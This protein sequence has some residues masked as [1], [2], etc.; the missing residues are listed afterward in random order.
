MIGWSVAALASHLG[1]SAVGDLSRVV[2]R[3][4]TLHQAT[5][6]DLAFAH[7][8]IPSRRIAESRAAVLLTTPQQWKEHSQQFVAAILSDD[9]YGDMERLMVEVYRHPLAECGKEIA[10]SAKV[11][12][13]AVIEGVVEEQVVIGPFCWVAKGS[14][15]GAGSQLDAGVHLYPGVDL[16]KD[17]HLLSHA[18]VGSQGFGFRYSSTG[19]RFPV[20][21]RAG[22]VIGAGSIIGAHSV[23][24]AG[25]LEPTELGERVALDSSVQVA[26]NVVIGADTL[27]AAHVDLAGHCILGRGVRM[28]GGAQVSG[29]VRVGDGATILAS[30]GVTKDVPAGE[31]WSGFPARPLWEWRRS[32]ARS[33]RT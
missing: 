16:G 21:H 8:E 13:T 23:V 10:V 1:R 27:I 12:P 11:D 32:V 29:G 24:A 31:T 7:A 17:C 9:P 2:E 3:F 14:R 25:F 26:H 22:V 33:Y 6:S 20:Q 4:S 30:A 18:V 19:E 5:S 15:V 28:G